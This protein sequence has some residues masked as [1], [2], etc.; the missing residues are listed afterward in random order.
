MTPCSKYHHSVQAAGP[1]ASSRSEGCRYHAAAPS[2]HAL[3]QLIILTATSSVYTNDP[4]NTD[5]CTAL[6]QRCSSLCSYQ[7]I[8]VVRACLPDAHAEEEGLLH[9]QQLC[10][11]RR[12]GS[13]A[14]PDDGLIERQAGRHVT[15]DAVQDVQRLLLS[16]SRFRA[17]LCCCCRY[18]RWRSRSRSLL[19]PQSSAIEIPLL[20]FRCNCGQGWSREARWGDGEGIADCIPSCCALEPGSSSGFAVVTRLCCCASAA[21]HMRISTA[22][23][24]CDAWLGATIVSLL[25]QAGSTSAVSTLH[26][27]S[28]PKAPFVSSIAAAKAVISLSM[29]M[30]TWPRLYGP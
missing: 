3:R 6:L 9:A 30:T 27:Q 20:Q 16:V 29:H 24:S 7:S 26:R 15:Q 18:R 5:E 8:E 21:D 28:W 2:V 12:L 1:A 19:L 22:P 4:Q 17:L 25:L 10:P 23:D 13:V 14:H 11:G